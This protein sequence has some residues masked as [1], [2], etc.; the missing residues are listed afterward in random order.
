[1][2]I[3]LLKPV[4]SCGS[5]LQV[6]AEYEKKQGKPIRIILYCLNGPVWIAEGVESFLPFM[7]FEER[8]G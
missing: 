4:T 2:T 3:K 7:F 6:M 1:M 8:L 5:C